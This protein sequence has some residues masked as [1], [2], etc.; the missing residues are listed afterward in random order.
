MRLLKKKHS[1]TIFMQLAE[2]DRS[3]NELAALTTPTAVHEIMKMA[4]SKPLNLVES[5]YDSKTGHK[6]FKLLVKGFK[7][8]FTP[9]EIK[10]D[11]FSRKKN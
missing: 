2:G 1:E 11:K 7:V 9:K 4:E 3:F 6:M 5:Y 8:D 10:I